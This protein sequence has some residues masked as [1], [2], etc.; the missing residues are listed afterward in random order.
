MK[1]SKLLFLLFPIQLF[2]VSC[3]SNETANSDAV[4]QSEIYQSYNISY[5]SGEKELSADATFRFGGSAGTTLILNQPAN[6]TFNDEAM[7]MGKSIFT[8]TYYEINRQV[9][10]KDGFKFV[11]TDNEKKIY[12]NKASISP[13]EFDQLPEK[14]SLK[15]GFTIS[16]KGK[17]IENNETVYL[18]IEDNKAFNKSISTNIIGANEIKISANDLKELK[19]GK[20]NLSLIREI[21]TTLSESTHLGGKLRIKFISKKAGINIDN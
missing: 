10:F 14:V 5:N 9:E 21:A 15:D 1:K 4:K 3:V 6:I 7:S 12:T 11:Y 8:G 20:I 17:P 19:P 16:W 18:S 13:I 2:I